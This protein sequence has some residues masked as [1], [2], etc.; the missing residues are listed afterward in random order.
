MMAGLREIYG[1]PTRAAVE[2][3]RKI[4]SDNRNDLSAL[5]ATADDIRAVVAKR[6]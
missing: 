1:A 5:L 6:P 3:A 2:M 4:C